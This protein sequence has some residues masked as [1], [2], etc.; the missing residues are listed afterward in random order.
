LRNSHSGSLLIIVGIVSFVN[1]SQK[2]IDDEIRYFTA[3]A[4]ARSEVGAKMYARENP[5]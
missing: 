1:K 2:V 3:H 5:A 4:L